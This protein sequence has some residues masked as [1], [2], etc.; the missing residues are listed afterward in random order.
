MPKPFGPN[1]MVFG[2]MKRCAA[3]ALAPF[4]TE[5]APVPC[6]AHGQGQRPEIAT[7][8]CH[9]SS[10]SSGVRWNAS[11]IAF[12]KAS[13]AAIMPC[14]RPAASI[15]RACI[16]TVEVPVSLCGLGRDRHLPHV[17]DELQEARV[18]IRH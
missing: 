16:H 7:V 1:S 8:I 12:A 13:V 2:S 4:L 10:S 5:T 9:S 6:R 3:F 17:L 14:V 11:L 15:E 18:R